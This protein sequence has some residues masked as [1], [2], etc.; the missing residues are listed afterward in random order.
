MPDN[1]L[2][3]LVSLLTLFQA[4]GFSSLYF[5]TPKPYLL[6]QTAILY[7][8]FSVV[9]LAVGFL[10]GGQFN[11]LLSGIATQGGLTIFTVLAVKL[12]ISGVKGKPLDRVFDIARP[13]TYIGLLIA[14]NIDNFLAGLGSGIMNPDITRQ[15]ILIF[16]GAGFLG[17]LGGG[18]AGRRTGLFMSNKLELMIAVAFIIFIIYGFL[19]L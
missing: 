11:I 17:F 16:A 12:I 19:L 5:K 7:M 6:F 14:I 15:L 13:G 8:I 18:I 3:A 1:Y 9:L 10:L 4:F 2:I